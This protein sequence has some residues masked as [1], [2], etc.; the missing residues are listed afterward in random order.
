MTDFAVVAQK[1]ALINVDMQ[2]VFVAGSPISAPK[3]LDILKKI[4]KLS[5]VLRKAGS[6]IIHT[7]H[8]IRQD[9]SNIGVMGD[10]MPG[11]KDG[12]MNENQKRTKLHPGLEV[13]GTDIII[14][15][16]RFGA[17][18]NT[19]LDLILKIREISTVIITGIA[20]NICCET[21]AREAYGLNYQVLFVSDATCTFDMEGCKEKT[22]HA[23]TCASLAFGFAEVLDYK[24]LVCK[25]QANNTP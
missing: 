24:K 25:I 16:P 14:E 3:G 21:T 8:V 7:R 6:T 11:V 2:N 12:F 23:A 17:F 15:K 4:N 10:I 20:T 1:S 9:G 22:L 13:Q 5:S 19:D 18:T